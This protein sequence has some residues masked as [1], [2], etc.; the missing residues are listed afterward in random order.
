[1]QCSV[2]ITGEIQKELTRKHRRFSITLFVLGLLGV[3]AYF[4]I[5]MFFA[6]FWV[7]IVFFVSI[8]VLVLGILMYAG[9]ATTKKKVK[10]LQVI[11]HYEFS[12]TSFT[13]THQ[14]NDEIQSTIKILYKNV[15]KIQDSENY[16]FIY[17]SRKSVIPVPKREMSPE[18]I[19]TLKVWISSEKLG[20]TGKLDVLKNSSNGENRPLTPEEIR[21]QVK[22]QE[23]QKKL[24]EKARKEQEKEEK[25]RLELERKQNK[26]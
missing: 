25:R 1:M 4:A 11:N 12:A 17:V 24:I 18:D 2:E 20:K 13:V 21:K 9:Y 14:R 8:I 6:E 7:E 3:F 15:K 5:K 26:K 23:K 22:L 16:L 19:S 10:G